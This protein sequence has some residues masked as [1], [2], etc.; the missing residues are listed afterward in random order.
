MRWKVRASPSRARAVRGHAG[1]VVRRRTSTCRCRGQ[2]AGQAVE[3]GGLAGA[4]RARSAPPAR[5]RRPTRTSVERG[6][7]LE[8]LADVGGQRAA[9]VGRARRRGR[10]RRRSR[11]DHVDGR[12]ASAGRVGSAARRRSAGDRSTRR[13]AGRCGLAT[14]LGLDDALGVLGVGQA[15]KPNRMNA[16]PWAHVGLNEVEDDVHEPGGLGMAGQVVAGPGEQ[17]V[18]QLGNTKN[19]MPA[20]DRGLHRAGSRR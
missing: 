18:E 8:A 12:R 15:P 6:D 17:L 11:H 10:R 3:Q 14:A 16:T 13:S 7:A 9:V 19:V 4:V 5:R 1:Q 2:H 20:D